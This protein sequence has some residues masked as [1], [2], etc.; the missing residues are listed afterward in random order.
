MTNDR[1]GPHRRPGGDAPI[2]IL[3]VEDQEDDYL[4]VR[5]LLLDFGQ[6]YFQIEWCRNFETGLTELTTGSFDVCLLDY[7]LGTHTGLDLLQELP[8]DQAMTTAILMLASEENPDIDKQAMQAGAMGYITKSQLNSSLIERSIRYALSHR[9]HQLALQDYALEL[10]RKNQE[11]AIAQKDAWAAI[12]LKAQFVSN[13]SHET[14]TP[15]NG[16]IGL[17]HLLQETGLT[18]DQEATLQS[19]KECTETLLS[20]INN[21]LNFSRIEEGQLDIQHIPFDIRTAI[22]ESITNLT[23]QAHRK[24]LD[25]VSVIH[26]TVP[27][28]VQGDPGRL[29][30]IINN[31]L[32]N[33]IKFSEAGE[34]HIQVTVESEEANKIVVKLCITDTGIGIS[35]EQQQQLFNPFTQ[36]DGSSTRKYQGA[37]LGLSVAKHIAELMGGTMGADSTVG[38]GSKFWVTIPF[39]LPSLDKNELS[40]SPFDA[41]NLRVGLIC[42]NPATQSLLTH[43]CRT[44]DVSLES[45]STAAQGIPALLEASLQGSAFDVV[46]LDH[47]IPDMDGFTLAQQIHLQDSLK[48]LPILLVAEGTPGEAKRAQKVGIAA[49]LTQPFQAWQVWECLRSLV[50]PSVKNQNEHSPQTKTLITKHSLR[51]ALAKDKTRILLVEDNAVNQKVIIRTLEKLGYRV[52]VVTS[53]GEAIT[54]IHTHTYH[55][56]LCDQWLAECDQHSRSLLEEALVHSHIPMILMTNAPMPMDDN[57]PPRKPIVDIL[58]KPVK[59]KDLANVITCWSTKDRGTS[60]CGETFAAVSEEVMS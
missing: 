20:M 44:W 34:I 7:H 2:S 43:H 9:L 18:S 8:Q 28:I 58:C 5:N 41:R 55:L 26:A 56:I 50:H 15:L 31:L 48:D 16:I 37:G 47:S 32:N 30:Q 33:A 19:I 21:I 57:P 39:T 12:Q 46:I 49:D 4:L 35:K 36:G 6:P 25:L 40:D 52:D 42:G 59:I 17:I 24:S 22:G 60:M 23:Q 14:R 11:L 38:Q 29:R 54:A 1:S 45:W 3:I 53:D 51:E 10:E 13:M 27:N